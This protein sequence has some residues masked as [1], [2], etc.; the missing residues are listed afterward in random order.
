MF[1][2][3]LNNW[4]GAPSEPGGLPGIC[5][6]GDTGKAVA[7]PTMGDFSCNAPRPGT[8]PSK[9]QVGEH[10]W[11][12]MGTSGLLRWTWDRHADLSIGFRPF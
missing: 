12:P 8:L 5:G 10:C 9:I 3:L 2:V 7:V 1:D 6:P 11:M 4:L